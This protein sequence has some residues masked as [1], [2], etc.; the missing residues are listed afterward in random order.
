[1]VTCSSVYY[2]L[3]M[4]EVNCFII[5]HIYFAEHDELYLKVGL[6]VREVSESS[7]Y[8]SGTGIG[9]TKSL[10]LFGTSNGSIDFFA[11]ST[12]PVDFFANPS[13]ISTT[14]R[15][16]DLFGIPS[17]A[18]LN[19]F[20]SDEPSIIEQNNVGGLL[21]YRADVGIKE[22]DED[23]GDFDASAKTGP[24][25]KASCSFIICYPKYMYHSI[26]LDKVTF[27]G[28]GTIY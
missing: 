24:E 20:T 19:G 13:G 4:F 22:L 28:S 6:I 1:M 18:T 5:F 23:F 10:D 9:L 3:C 17:S 26:V 14:S 12:E 25:P 15:E 21:E 8:T 7:P 16:V 11:S 27:L 2:Q